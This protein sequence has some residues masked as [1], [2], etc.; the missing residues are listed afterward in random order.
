[1]Y[2][3]ESSFR[4]PSGYVFNLN[5]KF[6]RAIHSS[7]KENMDL[8]EQCGLYN[9]LLK[10]KQILSYHH[11]KQS[12]FNLNKIYHSVILPDQLKHI[13]YPYEWCFSQLKDAALL[14]LDLQETALN[15][16]MSLK[17]SSAFNVQFHNGL[18]VMIDTLSF[19]KYEEG[20]PWV[21]YQQFCQHFLA[22]L[23]LSSFVDER[24]IKLMQVF[25]DGIPLDYVTKQLP[26]SVKI[27]PMVFIHIYLHS[28]AQNKYSGQVQLNK[29]NVTKNSALGL[30][31]SLKSLVNSIKCNQKDSQWCNYYLDNNYTD[32]AMRSKKAVINNWID[33]IKPKNVWD[34]GGNNGEF[35]R[36]FSIKGIHSIL[37]DMDYKA[38]EKSYKNSKLECDKNLSSFVLDFTNPTPGIGWNNKERLSI[39]E[40]SYADTILAL[41]LIH[42]LTVSNNLPLGH[43]A[44]F[45]SNITSK[46]LVIEFVPKAD[47]QFQRLLKTRKD[48]YSNYNQKE[49][50]KEFS[51]FFNIVELIKV[52][53]S[54]RT[55]YLMQK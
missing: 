44:K 54:Q 43:I 22:P 1:M 29:K 5:G 51:I 38:I 45:F 2:I 23:L 11:L 8:F 27:K 52:K 20:S 47:S 32:I 10:N 48:I 30:I 13:S 36:L 28:K 24:S 9:E 40:R 37:F 39:I 50:E 14:M 26:L 53:D 34:I 12:D 41:A 3:L 6:Y 18:P 55:L 17:D 16:G 31:G 46:Y 21:A 33:N 7:Y 15:Y 19:E 25:I 35:T 42:H 4:D 49:F